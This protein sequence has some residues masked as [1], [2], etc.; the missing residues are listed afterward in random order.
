[1]EARGIRLETTVATTTSYM[2]FNW[3]DPVVGNGGNEQQ[4]ERAK[5]LRHAIAIAVDWEELISIFANG[6][7]ISMQAPIAP[8]IFGYRD[9]REGINTTVYDWVDGRPVRKP[10]GRQKLLA[11]SRL[12]Q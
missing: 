10:I 11:R 1:M 12:S 3:L 7:G 9:G 6:R 8:G 5:K 2:A 4:R